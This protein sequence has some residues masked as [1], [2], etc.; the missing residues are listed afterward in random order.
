MS[1]LLI[2]M[3]KFLDTSWRARVDSLSSVLSYLG[4]N[5][6]YTALVVAKLDD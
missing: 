5:D 3:Q 4:C 2:K 6:W 1:Y